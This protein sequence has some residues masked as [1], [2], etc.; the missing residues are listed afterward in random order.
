[1]RFTDA[2]TEK[3]LNK[4]KGQVL[5]G[6]NFNYQTTKTVRR[7]QMSL[8]C[9]WQ[10]WQQDQLVDI[11]ILCKYIVYVCLEAERGIYMHKH[12]TMPPTIMGHKNK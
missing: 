12:N 7:L 11:T 1:M 6:R 3:K 10:K 4:E 9:Y 5:N 8:T 2:H